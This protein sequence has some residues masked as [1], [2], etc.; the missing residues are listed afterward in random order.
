MIL[1]NLRAP[2]SRIAIAKLQTVVI[3][4]AAAAGLVLLWPLH[5]SWRLGLLVGLF[6]RALQRL[7]SMFRAGMGYEIVTLNRIPASGSESGLLLLP[8]A[9]SIRASRRWVTRQ[10][11]T[12]DSVSRRAE[13]ELEIVRQHPKSNNEQ[14]DDTDED[15]FC[16][17][18][19]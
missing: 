11:E 17:G 15:E 6:T 4:L 16:I 5:I 14:G 18:S 13:A 3:V 1:R 7:A 8:I 2:V 12:C 9:G 10:E 19:Q